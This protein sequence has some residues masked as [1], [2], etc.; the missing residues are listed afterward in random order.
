MPRGHS[1][2]PESLR[3]LHVLLESEDGAG[4]VALAGLALS[5]ATG[6]TEHDA[7][8]VARRI[9]HLRLEHRFTDT[10]VLVALNPPVRRPGDPPNPRGA[11]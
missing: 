11:T 4:R 8:R 1:A 9:A 3:A 6:M 5:W 7:R 2:R 10:E